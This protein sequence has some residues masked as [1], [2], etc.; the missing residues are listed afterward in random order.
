MNDKKKAITVMKTIKDE[1]ISLQMN[2]NIY[3]CQKIID[4]YL[5]PFI[6]KNNSHFYYAKKTQ[7][8]K[9]NLEEISL[10]YYKFFFKY[11]WE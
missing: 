10:L 1:I 3:R 5:S 4:N 11:N 8:F 9:I 7:E 2:Y 6:N